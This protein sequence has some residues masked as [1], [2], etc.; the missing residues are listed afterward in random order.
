MAAYGEWN[1]K[2]ATLSHVTAAKEYGVSLDFIVQGIRADKLEYR[3]GAVFGS[4]YLKVLRSQLEQYITE[5]LGSQ[6]LETRKTQTE[7]REIKNEM[8]ELK[9]KLVALEAR[10]MEIETTNFSKP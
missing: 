10:K 6:Y 9:K 1:Q 8:A 5:E 4:S 3:D 2:G 7:L